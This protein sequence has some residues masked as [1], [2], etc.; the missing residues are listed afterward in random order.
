MS[1]NSTAWSL[2]KLATISVSYPL[3]RS[4]PS[5]PG[6]GR[7]LSH[8]GVRGVSVGQLEVRRDLLEIADE[9]LRRGPLQH[10]QE[11]SERLDR[12]VGLLEVAVALGQLPI[13]EGRNRVEGLDEEVADL[14]VLELLLELPKQLLVLLA[15]SHRPAPVAGG[16]ARQRRRAGSRAARGAR[17]AARK[18]SPRGWTGI[19]PRRPPPPRAAPIRSGLRSSRAQA[20]LRPGRSRSGRRSARTGSRATCSPRATGWADSAAARPR[21][22]FGR[23]APRA[24]VSAPPATARRRDPVVR[25][26]SAPRRS[27]TQGAAGRSTTVAC[28]RRLTAWR[29][30]AAHTA[31]SR[32]SRRRRRVSRRAGTS[33]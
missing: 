8:G 17:T 23:S 21:R 24:H 3:T 31:R 29:T 32:P 27:G 19:P 14:E 15:L 2:K 12:E 10:R 1:A 4:A 22:G 16:R 26:R 30:R 28:A 18:S 33:W 20:R 11:R 9:L 6:A 5:V 7:F 25:R 13:A